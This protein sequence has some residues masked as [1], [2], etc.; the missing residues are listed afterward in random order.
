VRRLLGP[1]TILILIGLSSAYAQTTAAERLAEA[2]AAFQ[3][4][5]PASAKMLEQA[6]EASVQEQN[7]QVEA[8]ARALTGESLSRR[9]QYLPAEK[10]LKLALELYGQLSSPAKIASIKSL[11]GFNAWGMG[12]NDEAR[13]YYEE[14]MASYQALNDRQ[15]IARL[16][17]SLT[18]FSRN[19]DEWM[20]H[21]RSGLE[22]A[23]EIGDR[24]VEA[25]LLH[26]WGDGAYAR[27]GFD[28]AFEHL[29]QA[30]S[31]LE[32]LGDRLELAG[33]LTSIGRLYRVHGH[34]DQAIPFYDRARKLQEQ[35]S[36]KRGVIQSLNAIGTALNNL[37]R[38]SEARARYEEALRFAKETGSAVLIR[39]MLDGLASTHLFLKENQRAA[40]LLEQSKLTGAQAESTFRLL[41]EARFRLGQYVAALEAAEEGLK[42]DGT[43]QEEVR[44]L[45]S[46]T[47]RALW[48]LGRTSEA[49]AEIR[50]TMNSIEQAR[51]AL[52]PADFMKQGFSDTDRSLTTLAIS[53]LLDS[54]QLAESL[55]MAEQARNRAFLDLLAS[56]GLQANT[57]ASIPALVTRGGANDLASPALALPSSDSDLV[58]LA[59]RL[60]STIVAYWVGEDSKFIWTVS[61]SGQVT[62]ARDDVGE[63]TLNTWIDEALRPSQQLAS[64]GSG[65][66][67]LPSRAG[68]TILTGRNNQSA[69]K[70]LYNALIRP[71]RANLP[72]KGGRLTII[73][74]GPLFRLSFA[75]LMDEKGR[76]LIEDYSI[77][78]APGAGVLTHTLQIKNHVKDLPNR[79]VFISNPSGM[80]IMESG[81][82]LSALPGSDEEV[83]R[84]SPLFAADS[85]SILRG[86]AADE[87]SV[88]KALESAKVIHLA[89]HGIVSNDDPFS[90]YL[91]LGRGR[92]LSTD[93]RLTAEEVYRLNLN[94]DLVVLSACRTGLGRISGDGVAGLAR[95]FFYAGAASVVATLWDVAD[96][97]ASQLVGSFYQMMAPAL[98]NDKSEALRT[99]QLRLLR[100]LRRGELRVDT[101]FG[102]LSLPE[103]PTLWAGFVLIGEP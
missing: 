5:D 30:R 85:V 3:R 88:R 46:E 15:A 80:P 51:H 58:A 87:M 7:H 70:R 28:V 57:T 63:A 72:S 14:A 23:R 34:A 59:S 55:A 94:A 75:A 12:N 97:P 92:D 99:A 17:Q 50:V 27:D 95:A 37:G 74:S 86:E 2:K 61:P 79:Y 47:A 29:N 103:D 32:E 8:E 9:G 49:L 36:D 24:G 62:V 13:H 81:K 67:E 25:S 22:V 38:Y 66:I 40:D 91:A 45:R 33:V 11:L 100:S 73:P 52:V 98:T 43:P 4:G 48:K 77:H 90:S 6:L 78:Y 19:E 56:K 53:V 68:D 16:H 93:G 65:T 71:I 76:Y 102:K 44:L 82:R 60:N 83:R 10:H 1:I 69:W 31:I 26:S 101:P 20:D 42:F 84:I 18:F 41:S 64:R 89:T 35:A 21:I 39:F 54:R 96:G